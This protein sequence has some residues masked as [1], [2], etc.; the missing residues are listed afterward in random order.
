MSKPSAPRWSLW[1]SIVLVLVDYYSTRTATTTTTATAFTATATTATD[2][3]TAVTA[4]VLLPVVQEEARHQPAPFHVQGVLR[5]EAVAG[6]PG[7]L[8]LVAL[9]GGIRS[10]KG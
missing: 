10:G 9:Y 3:A 7:T 4:R 1:C 6:L 8:L 5:P 2:T